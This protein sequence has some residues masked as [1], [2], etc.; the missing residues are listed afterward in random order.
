MANDKIE[1]PDVFNTPE[2]KERQRQRREEPY[3]INNNNYQS[4]NSSIKIASVN[5]ARIKKLSRQRKIQKIA[6]TIKIITVLGCLIVLFN[7]G[8]RIYN[9]VT[10]PPHEYVVPAGYTEM[11][12]KDVVGY[13]GSVSEVAVNYYN[14]DESYEIAY[15]SFN[16]YV[17]A[18]IELNNLPP[19]G[20]VQP[21]QSLKIPALVDE[22]NEYLSQI[23]TLQAQID[24][25]T[26]KDNTEKQYWIRDYK[27]KL[28]DS[29][30]GLAG[31]A[32]NGT[33]NE[34]YRIKDLIVAEN[35][36]S[37]SYIYEGQTLDIV[38]PELGQLKSQLENL[39]NE[40][41]ESLKETQNIK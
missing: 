37:S 22:N 8:S 36:L 27:V 7:I 32:S 40:L 10:T 28:G 21:Y 17:N 34:T 41:Y 39:K 24:E 23:A 5:T 2:Y 6:N 3:P 30:L 20:R 11:Q 19:N 12:S 35:K 29:L 15:G 38:N 14:H 25:Y 33:T 1:I 16:N 26:N 18:I 4:R 9:K 31:L 13:N